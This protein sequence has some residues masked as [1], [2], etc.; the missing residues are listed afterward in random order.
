MLDAEGGITNTDDSSGAPGPSCRA[1]LDRLAPLQTP[2]TPA[3]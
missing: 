2:G 3:P 1:K